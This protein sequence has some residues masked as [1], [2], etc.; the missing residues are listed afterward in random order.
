MKLVNP[1]VAVE[2]I[3]LL[4]SSAI[5]TGRRRPIEFLELEIFHRANGG[6]TSVETQSGPPSHDPPH[7]SSSPA[8]QHY[9]CL[10]GVS[11]AASRK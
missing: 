2:E 10:A 5:E 11:G 7:K 9:G 6:Y 3:V 4:D 1:C 8:R